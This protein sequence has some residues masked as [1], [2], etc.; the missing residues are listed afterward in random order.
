MRKGKLITGGIIAMAV[1]GVVA[2]AEQSP[3]TTQTAST[4]GSDTFDEAPPKTGAAPTSEASTF[5]L[6]VAQ[7]GTPPEKTATRHVTQLSAHTGNH[8]VE[9]HTDWDG[10]IASR[11]TAQAQQI[12]SA[13]RNWQTGT[14]Y[15]QVTVY[16]T[17][18]QILAIQRF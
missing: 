3:H 1:V 18:G 16:A 7:E 13:Y 15:A 12:A 10:R 11:Y 9:I 14:G 2:S 17:N 5:K 8:K 4:Q 6:W